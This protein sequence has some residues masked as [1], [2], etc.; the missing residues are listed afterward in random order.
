VFYALTALMGAISPAFPLVSI[1][2]W[3]IFVGLVGSKPWFA[4]ALAA[5][6]GQLV[7]FSAIYFLG[8]RYVSKLPWVQRKIA[9]FEPGRYQRHAKWFYGSGAL[10][11]MPPLNL[12]SVAAPVMNVS[13]P[14]FAAIAFFGRLLRL[15]VLVAF[16]QKAQ[17]WFP[18]DALPA[19]LRA[20]A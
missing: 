12:I 5:A 4:T 20:F 18:V 8:D 7:C 6:V 1:E 13:F 14:V 3:A 9:R 15:S 10:V 17:A 11:G 16:A 2:A 19:W